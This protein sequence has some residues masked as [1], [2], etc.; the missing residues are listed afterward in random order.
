MFKFDKFCMND[1][2]HISYNF[3]K[4]MNKRVKKKTVYNMWNRQEF[5]HTV[6][7]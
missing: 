1:K 6:K 7:L 3:T 5:A 4:M 2:I